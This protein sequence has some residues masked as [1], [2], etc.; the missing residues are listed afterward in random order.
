MNK[1]GDTMSIINWDPFNEL[2]EIQNS[3]NKIFDESVLRKGKKNRDISYW[4]PAID[5]IEKKDKY[6]IKAEFPG[7]PKED[8]DIN[9]SDNVLTVKGEKK[10]EKE[11]K[12]TNYYRSERVYGL[13]QRQLVLPPDVDAEKIKAN[14]KNGVLEIEIPKGEKAKPKK[15]SIS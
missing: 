13:F 8:I 9:V 4:E 14:Y 7:I 5:I 15:I 2:A 1:G 12:D 3:I 10:Q 6:I 11:E